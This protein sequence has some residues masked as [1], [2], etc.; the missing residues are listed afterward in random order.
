MKRI[1]K[2]IVIALSIFA[3]GSRV[4]F[5]E[6]LPVSID[7][8]AP[9]GYQ[10]QA[11]N[12]YSSVITFKGNIYVFSMDSICRP[13]INMIDE[14]NNN[15]I[16]TDLLNNCETDIYR[17]CDNS[18]HRFDIGVNKHGYINVIGDLDH[19]NCG[20]KKEIN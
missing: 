15:N 7:A 17:V 19:G 16:D 14:T 10:F 9:E 12:K 11:H 8:F 2:V 13:Y 3:I 20:S 1:N 5:Q 4:S 6:F 18:N